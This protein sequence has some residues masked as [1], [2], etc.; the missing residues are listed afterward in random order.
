VGSGDEIEERD[1]GA[2]TDSDL[3]AFADQEMEA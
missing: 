3:D 2:D 1:G